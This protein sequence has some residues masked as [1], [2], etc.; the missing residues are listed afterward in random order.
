MATGMTAVRLGWIAYI[1]PF[2]FVLSPA[3]LMQGDA[4]HIV[5][6][7]V[8][9]VIGVWI[10]SCGFV[11]WLLGPMN[12]L[13]RVLVCIAGIALLLPAHRI[14]YGVEINVGGA[15]LAALCIGWQTTWVR[16]R[17]DV[18]GAAKAAE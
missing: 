9:A 11:G 10:T 17:R 3:L 15:L 13:V 4:F 7:T 16:G 8:T 5:T 18:S 12:P 1:I 2:V 6:A 14:G